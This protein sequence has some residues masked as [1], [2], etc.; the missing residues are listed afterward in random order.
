[1]KIEISPLSQIDKFEW[2]TMLQKSDGVTYFCSSDYW[3]SFD[4]PYCL[5]IRNHQNELWGGNFFYRK[6]DT[7]SRSMV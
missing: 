1:M 6:Y 3:Q 7:L 2:H 5:T 4:D